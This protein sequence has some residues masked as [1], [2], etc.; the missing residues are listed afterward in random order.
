MSSVSLSNQISKNIYLYKKPLIILFILLLILLFIQFILPK[1]KYN[2]EEFTVTP[3][4]SL[5][6][7]I[8]SNIL[9][10]VFFMSNF[11]KSEFKKVYEAEMDDKRYVSF[12]IRDSKKTYFPVGQVV[13]TTDAPATIA[14][15]NENENNGLKYLMSS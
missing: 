12:W 13:L 4:P 7:T 11:K 1:I 5:A 15:I 2:K 10:K 9:K 8:P 3:I 14:D 6:P